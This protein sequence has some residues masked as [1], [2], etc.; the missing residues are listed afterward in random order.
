MGFSHRGLLGLLLLWQYSSALQEGAG[1]ASSGEALPHPCEDP[2][3]RLFSRAGQPDAGIYRG[4]VSQAGDTSLAELLAGAG[5]V[6]F[7]ATDDAFDQQD[8]AL[9]LWNLFKAESWNPGVL[10]WVWEPLATQAVLD[11][12]AQCSM[13]A[14][15][16]VE[17]ALIAQETAFTTEEARWQR[18]NATAA[19]AKGRPC[20]ATCGAYFAKSAG[21]AIQTDSCQGC[22]KHSAGGDEP[23]QVGLAATG[24]CSWGSRRGPTRGCEG[25]F[26]PPRAGRS[27][28]SHEDPPQ[29]CLG[30]S[31]GEEGAA[32][33][34]TNPSS[35]SGL[36][37]WVYQRFDGSR[38]RAG[39]RTGESPSRDGRAR[40]YVVW[41]T[42][43]GHRQL[44]QTGWGEGQDG[45]HGRRRGRCCRGPSGG[46]CGCGTGVVAAQTAAAAGVLQSARSS[47]VS[48]GQGRFGYGGRPEGPAKG[49]FTYTP[50]R[51]AAALGCFLLGRGVC[52][53][54]L[55][56]RCG[57]ESPWQGPRI[58]GGQFNLSL[59]RIAVRVDSPT[60][61]MDAPHS[62]YGDPTFVSL[63]RAQAQALL[64]QH[65]VSDDLQLSRNEIWDLRI[66]EGNPVVPLHLVPSVLPTASGGATFR[67]S[68]CSHARSADVSD[69]V[70]P[71]LDGGKDLGS[72]GQGHDY[73][74][75]ASAESSVQGFVS[76]VQ[77]HTDGY[78]KVGFLSFP[79][80]RN[81]RVGSRLSAAL[82]SGV[83]RLSASATA[84]TPCCRKGGTLSDPTAGPLP[85][86]SLTGGG[87]SPTDDLPNASPYVFPK[88]F[89]RGTPVV[90]RELACS[91]PGNIALMRAESI[92]VLPQE[93]RAAPLFTA[94]VGA[95]S[96]GGNDFMH[97]GRFTVFDVRRHVTVQR[98]FPSASLQ[99]IVAVAINSAPFTVQS[100]Q[101]LADTVEGYPIPQLVLHTTGYSVTE[102]PI[103]WDFRPLG[104]QVRTVM[105]VSREDTDTALRRA[106]RALWVNCDLV[107]GRD[108]GTLV[109]A[110]AL[111]ILLNVLPDDLLEVQHFRVARTHPRPELILAPASQYPASSSAATTTSTTWVRIIT[112]AQQTP[113]LRLSV[114]RGCVVHEIDCDPTTPAIDQHLFQLLSRHHSNKPLREPFGLVLAGAQP[115]AQGYFQEIIVLLHEGDGVVSCW[116]GRHQ[117][118]SLCANRHPLYQSTQRTLS[119]Q[120]QAQGWRLAVNGVPE[121]LAMRNVRFGDF[122]QPFQGGHPP[123]VAP[124]SW[125]FELAPALQPLAWPLA[126][127]FNAAALYQALR[128]RRRRLGLHLLSDGLV[129]LLGPTHGDIAVRTGRPGETDHRNACQAA[130]RL[131]DFPARLTLLGT[132]L[133]RTQEEVFVTNYPSRTVSTVLTPAPGYRGH[134]LVLM[135]GPGVEV[136][137][138]VPAESHV[139]LLPQRRLEHG[140]VLQEMPR[141]RPVPSSPEIDALDEPAAENT[142]EP[143]DD[144]EPPAEGSS[145]LQLR[146]V[147]HARIARPR[148]VIPTPLGRRTVA[149]PSIAE[150][151]GCHTSRCG[152]SIAQPDSSR[153]QEVAEAAL[154]SSDPASGRESVK[155]VLELAAMPLT[156]ASGSSAE[157]KRCM[158]DLSW[159]WLGFWKQNWGCIPA[160]PPTNCAWLCDNSG[161]WLPHMRVH[162]FTDGSLLKIGDRQ[163]CGWGLVLAFED[164]STGAWIPGGFAGG[165][166]SAFTSRSVGTSNTSFDAEVAACIV[167]LTWCFCLPKGA[168]VALWYDCQSAGDILQG[169]CTP[170]AVPS[171]VSL[172]YRLRSVAILAQ[173]AGVCVSPRWIPSHSGIFFNEVVDV[174][175]KAGAGG[176]LPGTPLPAAMWKM[177][178]S[179]LLPWAWLMAHQGAAFPLF[180]QLVAG[181]Y[182]PP[183]RVP[184][185]LLPR[186]AEPV[187][188]S[189]SAE[190]SLCLVTCNV[191]TF[192]DK[193]P[194]VL[195]Q[196]LDRKVTIAGLQET[197][198]PLDTRCNGA[199]FFEFASAAHKGEGGTSIFFTRRHPYGW[200]KGRPLYFEASHFQC[201]HAEAQVIAVQVRAPHLRLLCISAH[202]PH[203]GCAAAEI[204]HWWE[205]LAQAPWLKGQKGQVLAFLDGNAQ[206]GT[207][208]S[209][210]IGGHAADHET[211][212]GTYMRDWADNMGVRFPA[213][214]H[215][216]AGACVPN[217][218]EPT[219]FSPHGAGFRIDYV[220]V[221][222]DWHGCLCVPKVLDDFELLNR[223]HVPA[224]IEVRITIAGCPPA[225]RSSALLFP[226][227]PDEWSAASVSH[228]RD[229]L[230]ETPCVSW[231][232]NVHQH[233]AYLQQHFHRVA[234]RCRPPPRRRCRA[235][236][237]EASRGL[238]EASKVCRKAIRHLKALHQALL[239]RTGLGVS[240]LSS[241]GWS[242]Q[243][244]LLLRQWAADLLRLIQRDLREAIA[245]DKG[246]Y[247]RQAQARLRDA[248][249]PF[250]AKAFFASLRALRPPGKRVLKPF[251]ALIVDPAVPDDPAERLKQQQ[252]H[253]ADLE[254]GVVATSSS[255][256]TSPPD[257]DRASCRFSL[258]HLPTWMDVESAFRACRAGK[259]PGSDGLPDWVWRLAPTKAVEIW[260]PVFLKT[261]VRLC[262]PVQFKHTVLCT[263]FKGKGSP[264]A[265]SNHRAIA[266]LAGP[267][268]VLR[269][270][271]RPAIL[272]RLPDDPLHQGGIP[273]SLLQGAHQVVRV[274]AT[275]AEAL[276]A[277][278]SALFMDVS[279]AYY[280]VIRQAFEEGIQDDRQVCQILAHLG[281]APDSLHTVC[282][283]LAETNLMHDA[284]SHEQLILREY[285]SGSFFTLKQGGD[286]ILTRAGTRPGDSI[287]DALF[288]LLQADFMASLRDRMGTADLLDDP[289]TAVTFPAARLI[290]PIWADDTAILLAHHSAD[291]ILAK[292]QATLALVHEEFTRRCMLPNYARGKSEVLIAPRGRGAPAVRQLVHIRQGGLIS[293][294][295]QGGEQRV[296]CTRRYV[297][298]GGHVCDKP[299]H[300][301]D[302]CQHVAQAY[303]QI[304]PLRRPVLRDPGLPLRTRKLVLQSLAMSSLTST[305]PTWG[306]LTKAET[307]AWRKG[308]VSLVRTLFRD[309]R[310]T[311]SPTLPGEKEV[312]RAAGVAAPRAYLRAQRLLH[313]QRVC[314]TQPV[315]MDLL[316][317]EAAVSSSSWL[318]LLRED[319]EWLQSL[320]PVPTAAA[321]SF[322]EALAEWC[323]HE[324][325]SFRTAVRKAM[326]QVAS[327]RHEPEWDSPAPAQ[328]DGPGGLFF[329]NKCDASFGTFQALSAHRFARH[330]VRCAARAYTGS[331]LCRACLRQFWSKDRLARHL[332]HDSSAC[333]RMLEEHG[334]EVEESAAPPDASMACLPSTRVA[335]PL[336]P[337]HLSVAEFASRAVSGDLALRSF[338]C[339][340]LSP[341]MAR[342]LEAWEEAA[343]L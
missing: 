298:L 319:F 217:A 260:L 174:V 343:V 321:G 202:A 118:Q 302:I 182:E 142:V 237:S 57:E 4:C 6:F 132:P 236:V 42:G 45:N 166:L 183:D 205:A 309:D 112:T 19:D 21:P 323:V 89:D 71:R 271:L 206:V 78:R 15:D 110:D 240:P 18:L 264:A 164:T 127:S 103:P 303:K 251:S 195:Q 53:G 230:V 158:Q 20:S 74:H 8:P 326:L 234:A 72:L 177:L 216:A 119:D 254:A 331:T 287:A 149:A 12:T 117:G 244:V 61:Y 23:G 54:G 84:L 70:A 192:K 124:L 220:G 317:A 24:V 337:L 52:S 312:C 279:S 104:D 1:A 189:V 296:F 133:H 115:P 258:R 267:G 239:R 106:Q 128:L 116:D 60:A 227:D 3:S 193:R 125:C 282:S 201:V 221:P 22:C 184:D 284:D 28:R 143:A 136:L 270:Q 209:T 248:N 215:D 162:V 233:V 98:A 235:F 297:H 200:R 269:K 108:D 338:K 218:T 14:S 140:D 259:T 55:G 334:I 25:Y 91:H 66:Y 41:Q 252:R 87:P 333:L 187:T 196:L 176:V 137:R 90:P 308:Y 316:V 37:E 224:Q 46:G 5:E 126:I 144:E 163:V 85:P 225:R 341:A 145:L 180:D 93:I 332:Q 80:V 9:D 288:S 120:W 64:L 274:H 35:L 161:M 199:D 88:G 285:L 123:P 157:L 160:L 131:P 198:V 170:Q 148:C 179:P 277:S 212:A 249:D 58:D 34:S 169:T 105:H 289:I 210:A 83:C 79:E 139:T 257:I 153:A 186:P 43:G 265:I 134:F 129:R 305:A 313:F 81:F 165:P 329:C 311:G 175:A 197:R 263:L 273:Q 178:E 101:V 228:L 278:S 26:G 247:V 82:P 314:L 49:C 32:K 301:L 327:P 256:N 232:L 280:R 75:V 304:R 122:L 173:H 292:T 99:D 281:V 69:E 31:Y 181:T 231:G 111:G 238:L 94:P 211:V 47:P 146:A 77:S 159:P 95:F 330:G 141:P 243:D 152:S 113:R 306:P 147:K 325:A 291:G 172:A 168:E 67:I 39:S 38:A 130:D 320:A 154:V 340:W 68:S 339:S 315:L 114:L 294:W 191:Q 335:G 109:F 336:L 2:A 276:G 29:D 171:T 203:S 213:T 207:V 242:A 268:K 151:S 261:H 283:W 262:E 51:S 266:L 322:P 246:A 188:T 307:A 92:Q 190:L 253:F 33:G 208:Q 290:A 121:W 219:W 27:A 226:R 100:I 241:E 293:F 324:K 17:D 16:R 40:N 62:I 300:S 222:A 48:Q 10:W 36:M 76:A 295:P 328:S 73:I 63:A 185:E 318:G 86:C 342:W 299:N 102:R 50:S 167:A 56:G 223:D 96:W 286:V 59:G 255:F 44:S 65:E 155:P 135:I 30:P 204:Q 97:S 138:G 13:E 107:A 229:C 272:R 150:A 194:L 7:A 245:A 275:F 214:F 250:N 310:W 156:A 11:F